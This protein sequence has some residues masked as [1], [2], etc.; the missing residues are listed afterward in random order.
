MPRTSTIAQAATA[1][2]CPPKPYEVRADSP[3]GLLLRVQ[4]SGVRTYYVQVARGKRLRLGRAPDMTLTQAKKA[5]LDAVANPKAAIE[6]KAA[7]KATEAASVKLS[8]YLDDTYLPHATAHLKRGKQTVARV[9]TVWAPILKKSMADI[10]AHDIEAQRTKRLNAGTTPATVNRDVAALSGVF[11]LWCKA[12]GQPHP[13]RKVQPLQVAD[14]QTVRYLQP[15]EKKRLLAA[16]AER[17]SA[18]AEADAA[19]RAKDPNATP[20]SDLLTPM[21]VLSLHT[22][23][24]QGETFS[25]RWRDVDL[26][27]RVLT[28]VA[29]HAKGNATRH[30]PLHD[31]AFAVLQALWGEGQPAAALVFPS[32]VSGDRL[33]NVKRSWATVTKA[34]GLPDFRWH[35]MRHHFAS[36]LVMRGASLYQ[37]QTLLG[38]SNPRMTQRYARLAPAALAAAVAL[39]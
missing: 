35:D 29:S 10:T 36:W 20:R 17:D 32:P 4:P 8:D 13:L 16:L 30:V 27:Q 11:S 31:E 2:D 34:A 15:E 28:V 24:R 9:R 14:D 3:R 37:V 25:L 22:G 5:A 18:L 23:L 26:R 33:N 12:T 39:L 1:T 7:K 21:V 6:A 38:H 19:A